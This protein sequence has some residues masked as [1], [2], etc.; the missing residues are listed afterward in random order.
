MLPAILIY[1]SNL[2]LTINGKINLNALPRPQFKSDIYIPPKN[3]KEKIVCEMF[4]K[5]LGVEKVGVNE[6]FFKLGGDSL[7]AIALTSALKTHFNIKV[8]DVFNLRIP[9]KISEASYCLFGHDLLRKILEA[10]KKRYI[11]NQIQTT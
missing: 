11:D 8:S 7:K 5:I 1:M 10:I 9:K 3:Q 6:D 4:A 2:P